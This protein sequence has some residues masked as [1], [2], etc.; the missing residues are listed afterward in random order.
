MVEIPPRF[1]G[2]PPVNP[3]SRAESGLKTWEGA[4]GL[5][6]DIRFYGEWM[7]ERAWER[8]GHLYPKVDG[9]TV[10]AWLWA[11]TVQSPDPSW[12][13][14]VPLLKSGVLRNKPGKPVVWVEPG[15][16]AGGGGTQMGRLGIGGGGGRDSCLHRNPRVGRVGRSR[17]LGLGGAADRTVLPACL[18]AR[19][20]MPLPSAYERPERD[21]AL[22][23]LAAEACRKH[24]EAAAA[25]YRRRQRKRD[26][27]LPALL[28][29]TPPPRLAGGGR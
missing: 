22:A 20:R 17:R 23:R 27:V 26:K 24:A 28:P 13:G 3:R 16:G 19:K 15:A 4:Q 2:R 25:D 29:E 5:A 6:A 18:M 14:H 9:K 10:I 8:I 1:A 21:A 11:R 12:K 7:R